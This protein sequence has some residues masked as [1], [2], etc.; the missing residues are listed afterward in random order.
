MFNQVIYRIVSRQDVKGVRW[1]SMDLDPGVTGY[2][3]KYG[4]QEAGTGLVVFGESAV[5]IFLF[6]ECGPV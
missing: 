6:T 5:P 3:A 2:Y 1:V 4:C